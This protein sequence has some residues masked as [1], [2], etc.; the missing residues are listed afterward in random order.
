MTAQKIMPGHPTP[1]INLRSI[2]GEQ[3]QLGGEG[4][5]Q[6]AVVYRGRHC[7]LCR[8]YLKTLNSMLEA[9]QEAGVEVIAVSADPIERATGTANEENW[10]FPVAYALSPDQMRELGLYV[11]EP[12]FSQ[13]T[14]WPF[15]E[16]G[17]FVTNPDGLLQIVDISNAPFARPDLQIVL[18]GLKFI[19]EKNYP[20]RGT[21]MV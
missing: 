15:A 20:I 19:R 9:F 3:M 4:K 12:R 17:L 2:T 16:P 11:S 18:N 5:W 6:L 10:R 8:E 14:E 21:V 13:E 1:K 7:P